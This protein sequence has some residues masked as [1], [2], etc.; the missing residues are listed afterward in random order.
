MRVIFLHAN[1]ALEVK[2][3]VQFEWAKDLLEA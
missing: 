1:A 2:N 3:R